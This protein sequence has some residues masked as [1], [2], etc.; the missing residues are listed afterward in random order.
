MSACVYT[1]TVCVY[2]YMHIYH[3]STIYLL[4]R[5]TGIEERGY[6]A[7]KL[8]VGKN[9]VIKCIWGVFGYIQAMCLF[10]FEIM[11]KLHIYE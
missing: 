5:E 10:S 2:T 3:L 8:T 11:N 9:A 7:Q 1:E 6:A 4:L